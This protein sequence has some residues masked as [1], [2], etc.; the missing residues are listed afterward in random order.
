MTDIKIDTDTAEITIGGG[1]TISLGELAVAL[2]RNDINM[3]DVADEYTPLWAG[4]NI[5]TAIHTGS[6][7][8]VYLVPE[9][10]YGYTWILYHN[11]DAD[12]IP[13]SG[14]EYAS[15]LEVELT[16]S[17]IRPAT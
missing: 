9:Y 12:N 2:T 6:K 8:P 5:V 10:N 15:P 3:E 17:D 13:K 1:P 14:Y 4:S 11:S 7:S 16:Y